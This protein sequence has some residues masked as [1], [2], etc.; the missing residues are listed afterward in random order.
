MTPKMLEE[1]AA[2]LRSHELASVQWVHFQ[3]APGDEV[4]YARDASE[5]EVY[6]TSMNMPGG[7]YFVWVFSDPTPGWVQTV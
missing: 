6:V 7:A 5:V 1:L 3:K 4:D 2:I